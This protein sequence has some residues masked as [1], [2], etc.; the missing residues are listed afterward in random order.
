MEIEQLKNFIMVAQYQHI[1]L[2]A[3]QICISQ[4]ALSKQIRALESELGV[5]LLDRCGRTLHITSA[6]QDFLVFANE[7]VT[8]YNTLRNNLNQ[9]KT[10]YTG[11]ITIGT[12]PLMSQYGINSV[13]TSF[14]K[15]HPEIQIQIIEDKDDQVLSL[16]NETQVDFAFVY[17]T[18]LPDK[19]YKVVPLV[20]DVMVVATHIDHPL[21]QKK[22]I[23]LIDI[24]NESLILPDLCL[25]FHDKIIQSCLQAGFQPSILLNKINIQTAIDF[26][27]EKMGV[28]LLMKATMDSYK[29]KDIAI[30]PLND[31]IK[32]TFALAFPHGKKLSPS[33]TMLKNYTMERLLRTIID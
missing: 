5:T 7:V 1:T 14:L 25:G 3:E 6:G 4:S 2:A 26:V 8:R 31:P 32:S 20:D 33:A 18:T 24:A 12:V 17:T 29:N 30:I 10:T 15:Q 21:A 11:H 28:S 16:L 23:N 22:S 19:N 9:Y 27:A 13:L